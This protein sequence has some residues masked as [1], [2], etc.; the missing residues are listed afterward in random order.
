MTTKNHKYISSI[1][2]ST[3]SF[4][5]KSFERTIPADTRIESYLFVINEGDRFR[6]M[7]GE[8]NTHISNIYC[9]LENYH[10]KEFLFLKALE[11][12]IKKAE[13]LQ[14]SLQ[15][16]QELISEDDFFSELES[17]EDKYLIKL[18]ENFKIENFKVISHIM[19]RLGRNFNSDEI[20]EMFSIPIERVNDYIDDHLN[21]LH[22]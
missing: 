16:E 17:N 4:V 9:I 20:S 2:T 3:P 8:S 15:L 13:F 11:N 10:S 6:W 14:L 7:S 19:N 1:N 18:D 22:P 5:K 21:K 12:L